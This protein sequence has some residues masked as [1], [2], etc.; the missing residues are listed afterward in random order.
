MLTRFERN[1]SVFPSSLVIHK[2]V[3]TNGGMYM[4]EASLRL[5]QRLLSSRFAEQF[6]NLVNNIDPTGYI[7]QHQMNSVFSSSLKKASSTSEMGKL[8]THQIQLLQDLLNFKGGNIILWRLARYLQDRYACE[9]RWMAGMKALENKGMALYFVWGSD[10]SVAPL[11]IPKLFMHTAG[12]TAS[13]LVVVE[14]KGHF[15]MMEGGDGEF[16]ASTMHQEVITEE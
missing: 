1:P 13:K 12:L 11:N 4:R 5:S 2:V 7:A 16:W 10:D 6:S 14:G 3:F 15:W 8:K 9:E